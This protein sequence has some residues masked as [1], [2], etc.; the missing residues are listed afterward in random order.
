[1]IVAIGHTLGCEFRPYYCSPAVYYDVE[2]G[3]REFRQ[4][5]ARGCYGHHQA[6]VYG[7]HVR[8]I[9][10]LGRVMGFEVEY[11]H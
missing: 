1:M 11:F 9:Q 3:V 6:I 7:N 10:E 8:E 4:A 5:L 2:G